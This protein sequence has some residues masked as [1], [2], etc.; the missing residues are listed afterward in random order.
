MPKLL[1]QLKRA[2]QLTP[3]KINQKPGFR[4]SKQ[5]KIGGHMDQI[6]IL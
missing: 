3:T 2:I 4:M 1:T 6:S 5:T